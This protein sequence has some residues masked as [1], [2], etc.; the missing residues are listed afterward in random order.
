MT[1]ILIMMLGVCTVT[2]QTTYSTVQAGSYTNASTWDGVIPP[3]P[4]PSGS[5]L[6]VKHALT[7]GAAFTNNG[8]IDIVGSISSAFAFTNNGIYGGTGTFNG[9]FTNGG[10]FSPGIIL[11]T[12]TTT[13]ATAITATTATTGGNVTAVG[14]SPVTTRGVCYSTS[15]N[16]N[17]T[18]SLTSDGSGLGTYASSLIGL[19]AFTTYYVRAYATNSTGTSYGTE[20]SFRTACSFET[21]THGGFTYMVVIGANN[22]CWLD[23]NLGATQVA[24][25]STDVA[26]YG[27]LYQWGRLTDGHQIRTSGITTTLSSTDTPVDGNFIAEN[28]GI[29]DWRDPRNDDLW[30]GVSGVNNPCPSGYRLPTGPELNTER[31]SWVSNDAAGAFGSSLKLPA[32]G[33]RNVQNG[34]FSL[35]GEWGIYGSSTING[36][37][38]AYLFFDSSPNGNVLVTGRGNG[39]SV[40]CLRD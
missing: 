4:L 29:F 10:A 13:A 14:S 39:F 30:Q 25:S 32:A 33:F 2:A 26:S 5:I 37:F 35:V 11:A 20:V 1:T 34:V 24:T 15:P 18:N 36:T 28:S 31:E 16:P 23:R 17:I 9:A 19:T 8:T 7:M 6:H 3:N 22:K 38:S 27:D 21:I 40:R 12:V